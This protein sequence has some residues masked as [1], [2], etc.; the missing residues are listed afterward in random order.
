MN[1]ILK[2]LRIVEG[3]AFV[4]APS[5]GLALA[6]MG[7]DVIRFDPIGGG[8]DYRRWPVNKNGSC[9]YWVGLNKGKRSIAI[10]LRNERG[11]ELA[12]LLVTA[13]GEYA[14]IF[15]TNFPAQGWL[16]YERLSARRDD[17][18][19]VNI[20]GNADGTSEVDYTVN[21]A[22]GLPFV[23]G[24]PDDPRPVNHVLPAWDLLTGQSAVSGLLAAERQR[25]RTGAGQYL[26]IALSDV[27]FGTMGNLG[28]IA[29]HEVAT[30]ERTATGNDLF[31]AFG[32]DF[33]TADGRR[34]MIAAI[35]L[36]HW[37]AL[38]KVTDLGD[39]VAAIAARTGLDLDQEGDRYGATEAIAEVLAP[40][41][42]ARKLAAI[43]EAFADTGVCWGPYR[44]I[45][46]MLIEDPRCSLQNPMFETVDQPGAGPTLTP[47]SPV[48]FSRAPRTAVA[49]APRL[50]EHTDLILAEVLG[51]DSGAI[52]ALHDAGV[53]AGPTMED[54]EA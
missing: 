36:R 8:L 16:D 7:A 47:G 23:T 52:G 37:R 49:P 5:A 48:T 6:Q 18:I 38:V 9:L 31:G 21:C 27:A 46:Q 17:L 30:S 51:L 41:C 32:R 25:C 26:R 4:A 20:T 10:D 14:G 1:E 2:G 42:G 3:S 22:T 54:A 29:E 39:A 45:E 15:L 44:N 40:W 11:R 50:G 43:T 35:T 53:V 28:F 33:E 13:P 24:H 34:V 12:A 19:M